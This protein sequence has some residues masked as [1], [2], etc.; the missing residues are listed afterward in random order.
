MNKLIALV[1]LFLCMSAPS[2]GAE[3]L[4]THSVKVVGNDSYK[5]TKV[6][7]KAADRAGKDSF[8]AVKFSAKETGHAGK[9]FAKLL[10]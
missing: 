9:T 4:V 3:H 10:F 5:P 6:S 8:K 1:V 2:F 7:A